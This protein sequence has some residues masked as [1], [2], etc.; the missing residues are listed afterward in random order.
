MNYIKILAS[1]DLFWLY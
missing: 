1:H